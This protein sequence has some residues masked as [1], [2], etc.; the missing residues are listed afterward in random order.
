MKNWIYGFSLICSTICSSL[1][2]SRV[3]MISAPTK[4]DANGFRRCFK[5]LAEFLRVVVLMFIPWND[6]SKLYPAI[7][8]R[9]LAGKRQ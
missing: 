2:P 8:S 4:L 9:E 7:I 6:F 1:S 3:L 5:F